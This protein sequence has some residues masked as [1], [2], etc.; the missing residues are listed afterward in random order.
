VAAAKAYKREGVSWRIIIEEMAAAPSNG[1][2]KARVGIEKSINAAMT[3]LACGNLPYHYCAAFIA[4]SGAASAKA[5]SG[6][7]EHHWRA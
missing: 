7:N 5:A 4:V 3:P 6:V 1:A 2:S